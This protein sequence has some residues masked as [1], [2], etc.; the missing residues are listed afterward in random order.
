MVSISAGR[1][2]VPYSQKPI[3]MSFDKEIGMAT[4][5]LRVD[6]PVLEGEV[7]FFV[8]HQKMLSPKVK[9]EQPGM[10][11]PETI[12]YNPNPVTIGD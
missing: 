1:T 12:I 5:E 3:S 11:D 8:T 9:L 10:K 6:P 2:D 4:S 7:P